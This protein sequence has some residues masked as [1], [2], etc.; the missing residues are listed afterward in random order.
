M[1]AERNGGFCAPST[2]LSRASESPQFRTGTSGTLALSAALTYEQCHTCSTAFK[3]AAPLYHP[4][5]SAR[6]AN[7]G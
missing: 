6:H 3:P 1:S 7:H 4:P 2:A 5:H